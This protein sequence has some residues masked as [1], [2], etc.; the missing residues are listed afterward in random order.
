MKIPIQ[1]LLLLL[2]SLTSLQATPISLFDGKSLE[3]WEYNEDI[4]RVEDGVITGGSTT[5][6]IK[7]NYFI[8]TKQSFQNFELKL[9]IKCSGDPKT[10]LINSGIQIRSIRAGGERV[11]GYQIDCGRK[12]FGKIYDE[13]RR[14]K[15]IAMPV[16][17]P[18][19]LKVIDTYGWNDYRIRAEGTRIR[20]W[21]NDVL[22]T[23]YTEENPNI[24]LDGIIAP[25]V[26]SGG[27]ALVQFKDI[28]IEELP[29]TPDA[30]TWESLGGVKEAIQLVRAPR[31]P[32]VE[33]KGNPQ[34]KIPVP[35]KG[36]DRVNF[37]FETGDLQGWHKIEGFLGHPV[38]DN[39]LNRNGDTPSNK[40]GKFFL[41][42]L[43][44][45]KG[46]AS[47][48]QIGII[49]SPVFELTG[50]TIQLAVSGGRHASTFVGLYTLDGKEIQRASG[51]NSELFVPKTWNVAQWVGKP[52][53]LRLVDQSQGSWGH[54]TLDAFSAQG[55]LLPEETKKR[56]VVAKPV[57]G[58]V[59][60][61]GGEGALS[62][63]EQL[64]GFTVPE[65][66]VIELVASEENG[67][68]NPIDMTFDDAGRL[69][70]QTARM[71]P[72]DPAPGVPFAEAMKL[73]KDPNLAEKYPKVTDFIELYKLEKRGSDQILIIDDPTKKAT[74]QLHVW[75]DGLTIPQSIMPYKNGAFVAHG[76][77]LFFLSDENGDGKQDKMTPKFTGFGIFDTHTM[78]HSIVR[79]PGGWMH[80]S[81][82][83]VNSGNVEVVETGKKLNVTFS[84]NLRFKNDGSELEILNCH[85][86]NNWGYQVRENGQWYATSANDGGYSVLPFEFMMSIAG[87][88]NDKIR[89][90]SPF[91][92]PI[93]KFRVGASGISGL[94][95][96]ED[97]AMSFPPEWKD[98]AF[99]ANPMTRKLNAVRIK[100]NKDGSVSAEHLP[101]F[102][103]SKDEW[104][105]PVNLEFGPDGCLYIADWYNKIISHNSIDRN[106]PDRDKSN[107]RIWRI[108]HKSQQPG[109]IPNLIETKNADL[110]KHLSAET[111]WEK[112]AAWHQIVDRQA[113]ELIPQIKT[114]VKDPH[115]SLG[116]RVTAIWCLEGLNAF[117]KS[118]LQDLMESGDD[119]IKREAIRSLGTFKPSA[120][121]VAELLAPY[122]EDK[123]A[124]VRSQVLRTL[125]EVKTANSDT[126]ALLL[127]ACKPSLPGNSLGGSYER[128]FE[129]FLA[130]KALESYTSYLKTFLSSPEGETV[131][132]EN[133]LWALQAL[134]DSEREEAFIQI[135]EKAKNSAIDD[136]TFIAIS[137]MLGND[138]VRNAVT[139]AFK[140]DSAK[141]LDLALRNYT[142]INGPGVAL[143]YKDE[144]E[145]KLTS[146]DQEKVS[147]ALDI[148]NKLHSPHHTQT[149]DKLAATYKESPLLTVIISA[150][151]HDAKAPATFYSKLFQDSSLSF[152]TRLQALSALVIKTPKATTNAAL[153]WI[154]TL[155]DSEKSQAV[156]QLAYSGQGAAVILQLKS[157]EIITDEMLD[158]K[159]A[160]IMNQYLGKRNKE[161]KAIMVKA[162]KA[163]GSRKRTLANKVKAYTE[164]VPKLKG[165]AATGQ[166]LYGSCLACHA[167]GGQGQEI[168]PPLDG[169]KDRDVAHL[170]TAIMN[171]DVAV[172]AVYGLSYA[173]RTDGFAV[174]GYLKKSD[175]SGVIIAQMGGVK[176]FIPS[177][178]LLT[179]G[180]VQGRSFMP[181]H[182][183]ELEEQTMADLVEYIKGIK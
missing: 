161:M 135:W 62:P 174:E 173:V 123:N 51:N 63:A 178:Q 124:A 38:A 22:A 86:D 85:K 106:H 37:D 172:E 29:P 81:H 46:S 25:Q 157:K 139:P 164:S 23:D 151:G 1:S 156:K 4:W 183:S 158:Y 59:T 132:P 153:E 33:E 113:E 7:T 90:Y 118:L 78:A 170:I 137:T 88:G 162:S 74:G 15:T 41:S 140:S 96:S 144:L 26:H 64:A 58:K 127:K 175:D 32:K 82:G 95:F 65:G 89:D 128:N 111:S 43:E 97:G 109:K 169:G 5:E 160:V 120:D 35:P 30:P 34:E 66:F 24:A 131:N 60:K 126:I 75:A 39:A 154:A 70:T 165:N 148:I 102:L 18:A 182:Y 12:W 149:L 163:E 3:G 48:K 69:W 142:S 116:T 53:Y 125:E 136:N 68:I 141:M 72:L 119:D 21:I 91:F 114:V 92:P 101:D 129:R 9:T 143:F 27:V 13:H 80:F 150:F 104:F 84:K 56:I 47:D 71:Y 130:R 122:L 159:T 133:R 121:V 152:T 31:P 19:L 54:I 28:T 100:R 36:A 138:K 167:V 171:P 147:E 52:V 2:V 83:A 180:S 177:S 168:A 67:L 44:A 17:E 179:L 145:E 93:H 55:K 76:S 42:S 110:V 117:D 11:S 112:R 50:D 155:S 146:G 73:M 98:V 40:E 61:S 107:G 79:G 99:L 6:K 181:A 49:E 94:A 16:D 103:S 115:Q 8:S 166:A 77:E 105:R 14:K 87:N 108:R 57:S 10:G 20:V 176:T 134:S 45:V